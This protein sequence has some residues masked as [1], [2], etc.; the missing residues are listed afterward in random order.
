MSEDRR[1][2]QTALTLKAT[3]LTLLGVIVSIGVTVGFSLGGAW[4]ARVLAGAG[5]T[6]ALAVVVKLASGSRRGPLARLANWMVGAPD[7]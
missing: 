6:V 3:G 7:A 4:W 1:D 2:A 5:V